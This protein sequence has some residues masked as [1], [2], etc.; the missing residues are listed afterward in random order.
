MAGAGR[1]RYTDCTTSSTPSVSRTAVPRA[2]ARSRTCARRQ[3]SKAAASASLSS[4]SMGIGSGPA[5]ASAMTRP[6]KNW[7]PK[8]GTTTVG[9]PARGRFLERGEDDAAEGG[10]IFDDHRAEADVDRRLAGGEEVEQR[11]RRLVGG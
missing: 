9:S 6:Q 7:S 4:R 10:W 11:A 2:A 1:W 5:P 3:L 8:N